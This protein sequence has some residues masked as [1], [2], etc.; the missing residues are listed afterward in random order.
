ME[1]NRN[2]LN[3]VTLDQK[4]LKTSNFGIRLFI[5]CLFNLHREPWFAFYCHSTDLF[6]Q[7]NKEQWKDN[8]NSRNC[9]TFPHRHNTLLN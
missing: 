7:N 9:K 8:K 4:M 5:G 1:N 6:F 3:C 2:F